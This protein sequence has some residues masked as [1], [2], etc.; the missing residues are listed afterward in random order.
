VVDEQMS[1]R[2]GFHPGKGIRLADQQVWAFPAPVD[3][4]SFSVEAAGGEYLDLIRVI[5]EAEDSS[6]LRMAE[7]ALAIFLLGQNYHLTAEDYQ[8]L[9]TFEPDSS[10]LADAQA[11]FRDL[12]RAHVDYL[13]ATGVISVPVSPAPGGHGGGGLARLLTRI[14]SYRPI[15]RWLLISRK[16]EALL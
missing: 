13:I 10:E 8:R 12:A 9:L 2:S 6:E 3:G 5:L 15:R 14:R 1:R 7:L 11:A 16:G 4:W